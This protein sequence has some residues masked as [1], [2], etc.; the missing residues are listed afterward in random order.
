VASSDSSGTTSLELMRCHGHMA[1]CVPARHHVVGVGP[2]RAHM[3]Y[4]EYLS[5]S[6]SDVCKL[7]IHFDRLDEPVSMVQT[8]LAFEVVYDDDILMLLVYLL[9]V[10][11]F[12]MHLDVSCK[13]RYKH[14]Q[15][16]KLSV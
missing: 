13:E 1:S 6:G 10:V 4:C 12:H 3:M 5:H 14:Q 8:N 11:S 15:L 9:L 16:W 7:Y 2:T